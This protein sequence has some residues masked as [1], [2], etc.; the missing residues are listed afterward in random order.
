MFEVVIQ[1]A[2]M[3]EQLE[4]DRSHVQTKNFI[5]PQVAV[6]KYR[7]GYLI[8][9]ISFTVDKNLLSFVSGKHK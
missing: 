7:T 1:D 6:K 9:C 8:S 2:T 4:K 3:I 5:F